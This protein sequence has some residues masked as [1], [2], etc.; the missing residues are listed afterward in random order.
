MSE[1]GTNY[2]DNVIA[3]QFAGQDTEE[4]CK[5]SLPWT[6]TIVVGQRT[7][8]RLPKGEIGLIRHYDLTNRATVFAVQTDNIGYE[9]DN[10]FEIIGRAQGNLH[11]Y[12][13]EPSNV[14]DWILAGNS[15]KA[16]HPCSTVAD[17]MMKAH[18]NPCSTVADEMVKKAL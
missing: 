5:V 1:S 13:L 3:N 12:G 2:F 10:G 16:G 6:R 4:R 17:G 7:G 11:G 8:Q 15:G 9:T 14:K 18:G